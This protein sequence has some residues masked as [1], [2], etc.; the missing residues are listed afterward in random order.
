MW[1]W[2]FDD[3]QEGEGKMGKNSD[4]GHLV[5]LKT[6][7]NVVD[8]P[9]ALFVET[10]FLNDIAT[11]LKNYAADVGYNVNTLGNQFF[12]DMAWGGLTQTEFFLN[13]KSQVDKNRIIEVNWLENTLSN[14]YT[15]SPKGIKA[16]D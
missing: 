11:E 15:V 14:Q 7:R 13:G 9:Q 1:G 6:D 4:S 5:I 8:A 10:K 16:C 12:K 3:L 2:R